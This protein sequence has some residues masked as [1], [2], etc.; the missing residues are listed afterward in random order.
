MSIIRFPHI[1]NHRHHD[2]WND[3]P[4]VQVP[5]SITLPFRSSSA[6]AEPSSLGGLDSYLTSEFRKMQ[7]LERQM[8]DVQMN[9]NKNGQMRF[10]CNVAGYLPEELNVDVE[11][12]DLV[13]KGEHK[14][15]EAGQS[16][17]RTFTRRMTLPDGV[18]KES[19][20]CNIDEKGCL[21]V[22]AQRPS[23]DTHPARISVPIG[24]KQSATGATATGATTGAIGGGEGGGGATGGEDAGPGQTEKKGGGGSVNA[25]KKN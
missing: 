13:I 22:Q 12:N 24:F 20:M 16:V 17:H 1:F 5:L 10:S 18:H 14:Q 25:N 6:A 8:I 21:S 4:L 11:G 9:N 2:Y 19:I 3:P 23:V 15:Q 7:E